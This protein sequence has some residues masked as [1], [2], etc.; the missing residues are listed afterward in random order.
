M[1][2]LTLNY[3]ILILNPDAETLA[4]GPARIDI[5]LNGS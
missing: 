1:F 2:A 4:P 5:Q 3:Q